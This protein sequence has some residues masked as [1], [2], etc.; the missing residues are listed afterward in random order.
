MPLTQ[1]RLKCE[2]LVAGGGPAGV[3]CAI[4]AA[5]AGASVILLQDRPVLGGNAS[6]EVRM[7]IVGAD[8]SGGRG[9]RLQTEAREGGI[10]EEIRLESAVRDP[11]R[12]ASMFDLVLYEKVRA[13]PNIKLFLNTTA[14]GVEMDGTT[15]RTVRADRQSTE[16]GFLID[17]DIFVDCTG[18]GR[19]GVEAG[20]PFH[21]GR[22]DKQTYQESLAPDKADKLTLG[23]TLLFQA[24]KHDRPMPFVA[25][26]WARHFTEDDLKMRPHATDGIDRGTEYGY[27]WV[28]WGGQVDTIKDNEM[29]RD[30]LLAIML[31]VWDHIKNQPGH[32]ADNWALQWF[33]FL[34]GKRE[35]RR[36][37]GKKILT[38]ADVVQS[39]HQPD[40]I[41][42]G[43][44]PID[45]HP[46]YGIDAPDE[47]ACIAHEVPYLFDIP[48]RSCV[49]RDIPNLMFAGRNISASHIAFAS[50]RVMATCA[51]VGQGVGVSAA[52]AI[53][54]KLTPAEI[55]DQPR[56]IHDIQQELLRTDCYLIGRQFQDKCDPPHV[57]ASSHQLDGKPENIL[58]GQTR[59]IH[60]PKGAPPDRSLP[61][62]HRWM[63]GPAEG[64][65]ATLELRWQQ[66]ITARTIELIFDTGMHRVLTL[67]HSDAYVE[68]MQWGHPQSETVRDYTIEL[69]RDGHVVHTID[70]IHNYLR[71]RVHEI[72]HEAIVLD[73]ARIIVHATNGL[74]FA[75]IFDVRVGC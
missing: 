17:A 14:V 19:L 70:V 27:W 24:K 38:E 1:T 34:P 26:P 12:S 43:G 63:S 11:Q 28:E 53:K 72:N 29:I 48:L 60:G 39:V 10:I 47:S 20:A 56:V 73:R 75:S 71:R 55:C 46:C 51:V 61:G 41:A 31:G 66:P 45:L 30:E 49:S 32:C 2:V 42:Y 35:S 52:H 54:N 22:E 58:T 21:M 16:D 37:I 74:E 5:R 3:P 6:S 57:T 13:E 64:F 23:S 62:S 4:A 44:W 67:S 65:P 69:M 7:H 25:P 59:S 50:T 40:A 33:G 36:F 9:S 15:I 8:S 68:H 18:D